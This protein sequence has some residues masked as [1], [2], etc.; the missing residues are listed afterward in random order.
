MEIHAVTYN[1]HGLPWVRAPHEAIGTWLAQTVRAPLL[2]FQEVFT[3]KGRAQLRSIL[4]THGYQVCEP[5]D[6]DV[7]FLGS[8]L[9]T[10]VLRG[11]FRVLTTCFQSFM[12]YKNVEIFANKGFQVLWLEDCWTRRRFYLV[13]THTNSDPEIPWFNG[14]TYTSIVNVRKRQAEQILTYFETKMAHSAVTGRRLDPVLVM[15]DLNQEISLHPHLRSL[16]PSSADPRLKKRTFIPT[17]QDLDH[18]A[19]LPLQWA[20]STCVFCLD[21]GPQ[22]LRCRVHP[23][24]WSDHAPV[25]M[26]LYIP[27]RAPE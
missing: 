19:W 23:Q 3:A 27:I 13:N 8:G 4:E 5:L 21:Q 25:E 15:G 16:H 17:G 11:R 20:S 18:V 1:I 12:A 6:G 14:N 24:T 22:L 9:L 10:A 26:V 7:S 2:C